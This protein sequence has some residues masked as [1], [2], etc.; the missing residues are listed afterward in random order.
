MRAENESLQGDS[1]SHN[2][3]HRSLQPGIEKNSSKVSKKPKKGL[4]GQSTATSGQHGL[5]F[6]LLVV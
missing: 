6:L 2:Q 1:N 3:D 5:N 4:A